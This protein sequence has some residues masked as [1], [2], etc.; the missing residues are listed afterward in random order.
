MRKLT[1]LAVLC[2]LCVASAC[3]GPAP[4]QGMIF[5]DINY[6]SY[7]QG[8]EAMGPGS[9]PGKAQAMS[10]LSLVALGD[11]SI[12]AACSDGGISKIHT[13]DHKFTN[14]LGVYQTWTTMVTGE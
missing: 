1:L 6:P 7:Y 8:V 13:V 5:A 9:K 3:T 11:A 4:L 2:V 10:I 12:D 14:I